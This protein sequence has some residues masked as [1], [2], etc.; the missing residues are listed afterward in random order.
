MTQYGRGAAKERRAMALLQTLGFIVY[1]SAGSH[2]MADLV[3]LHCHTPPLLV[4]V[5]A[6]AAGPFA[7]FSPDER[8]LLLQEARS[9]GAIPILCWCP[10]R[11]MSFRRGPK[12]SEEIEIGAL[13]REVFTP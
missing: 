11:R 5:K 6:S 8:W 2:G 13:M 4:Q 12:W 3:A 10:P 9:C 7:H 1:R